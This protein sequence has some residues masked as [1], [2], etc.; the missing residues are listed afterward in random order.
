MNEEHGET[1]PFREFGISFDAVPLIK[2]RQLHEARIE[3]GKHRRAK[4]E[5]GAI[6]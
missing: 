2:E 4:V 1:G 3:A 6:K 5:S